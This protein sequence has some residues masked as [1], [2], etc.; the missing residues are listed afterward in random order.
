MG[1][2]K[3]I[4]DMFQ[5]HCVSLFID[6]VDTPLCIHLSTIIFIVATKEARLKYSIS[7][8]LLILKEYE[9]R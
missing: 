7:M 5:L 9:Q 2:V 8:L 1:A 6:L 3:D 4:S